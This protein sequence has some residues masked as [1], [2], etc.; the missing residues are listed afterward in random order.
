[1]RRNRALFIVLTGG[2]IAGAIDITY[3]IVFSGLRGV[4]ATRVLQSVAS[5]LL[6]APAYQGG[7]ST[8]VLGLCLHFLIALSAAA[9]FYLASGWIVFLTR[10]A[11][12]SG[13]LYGVVIYAVMNFVVLPLSAFPQKVRFPPLVLATG[14][15]VH[16]FGIGLPMALAARRARRDQR[17]G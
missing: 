2:A 14:L 4:S 1:M 12:V 7:T 15:L 16:M 10:Q 11:V 3:A 5:G 13:I 17:V 8:A 6:G 9:I